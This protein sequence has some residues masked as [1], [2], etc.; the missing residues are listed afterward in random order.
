MIFILLNSWKLSLHSK[1]IK[2]ASFVAPSVRRLH[3]GMALVS[4]LNN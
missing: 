3:K 1:I 2:K 4:K